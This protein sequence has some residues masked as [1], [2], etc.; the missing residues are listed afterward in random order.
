M[1]AR[2]VLVTG[3]AGFVGS[4]VVRDL[5]R[6]GA[7]PIVLDRVTAADTLARVVADD[8]REGL[9][10]EQGDVTDGWGLMRICERHSVERIVHLASPLTGAI[11]ESPRA[12]WSASC[13]MAR[14]A[15]CAKTLTAKLR[16]SAIRIIR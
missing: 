16:S 8:E 3:G 9:V 13:G 2:A 7:L 4:Y 10:V 6:A 12:T 11:G 5:L 15:S 1:T 14:T